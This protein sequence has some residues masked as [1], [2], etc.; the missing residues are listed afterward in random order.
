MVHGGGNINKIMKDFITKKA[1]IVHFCI[2]ILGFSLLGKLGVRQ[3]ASGVNDTLIYAA[4]VQ[5][6][7]VDSRPLNVPVIQADIVVNK[8]V[9]MTEVV[10]EVIDAP[11][12]MELIG[13]FTVKGFYDSNSNSSGMKNYDGVTVV[14]DSSK[15]PHGTQI[16]IKG[17][18]I[19]QTQPNTKQVQGDTI[20]VY[21]ASKQE[22]DSFG[23]KKLE[24]YKVK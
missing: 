9:V 24:V 13:T 22:A 15:I 11:F 19:R 16:W 5:E 4:G 8:Q 3:E 1:L 6:V 14:A 17:V 12:D 18:G 2:C 21:F 20:L 10:E 7:D 23:E